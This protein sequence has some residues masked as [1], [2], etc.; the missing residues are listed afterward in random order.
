MKKQVLAVIVMMFCAG[1]AFAQEVPLEISAEPAAAPQAPLE[2]SADQALE[3][4]RTAKTY[5]ARGKAEAAQGDLKI[6][7]D[8]MVA[9][10]PDDANSS[11]IREVTATGNVILTSPPYTAQGDRAVYDIAGGRAVLTGA[12]LRVTGNGETLTARDSIVYDR[13]Q[14]RIETAGGATVTRGTDMLT[15]DRLSAA[16][17]SDAAGKQRI[18]SVTADGNVIITTPR[19]VLTGSRAV[20]DVTTQKIELTGQV[21]LAQGKNRLEGTRATLDL[22][23]GVSKLFADAA[24][25]ANGR[26]RGVFYPKDATAAQKQGQ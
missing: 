22:K 18:E 6:T 23:T 3:W 19:D 11:D 26:V 5:T 4:N 10:Y 15:A 13:L 12:N 1:P 24:K 9:S 2:I 8:L 20:Y 14:N 17:G 21:I 16:L 7:S 25:T